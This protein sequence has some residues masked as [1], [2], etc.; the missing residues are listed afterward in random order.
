M[1]STR[2]DTW[3]EFNGV[4]YDP[5]L[6]RASSQVGVGRVGV[7]LLRRRAANGVVL[8]SAAEVSV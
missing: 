5:A 7:V 1:A 8:A 4:T 2:R 3:L 6:V